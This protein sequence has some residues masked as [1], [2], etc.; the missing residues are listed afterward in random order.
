[1][2][3]KG[4]S[5]LEVTVSIFIMGLTVTALMNILNWSNLKYNASANSWKE[6]T[7][8]TEARVWI[9]NQILTKDETN[10]T[11]KLLSQSIKCPSGFG[12]NE[13][14]VTKHD[15]DTYFVKIGIFED[16]NKNGIADSDETTTRLFCF[17]RRTA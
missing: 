11:L 6:R 16:R 7:C 9:R 2:A 15:N 13:L 10:I 8:L 14:K 4:F 5:L 17:R 12:Y 1:M 3:K